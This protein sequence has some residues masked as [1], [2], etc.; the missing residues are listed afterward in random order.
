MSD[1]VSE[2]APDLRS[3]LLPLTALT[4]NQ[5]TLPLMRWL[6]RIPTRPGAGVTVTERYIGEPPVR[7]LVSTP[8]ECATGAPA[9]LWPH[10]GG[11][12]VGTPQFEALGFGRLAR[13]LGAVVVAPAYRLVSP[14]WAV[15]RVADWPPRSRNAVG[16]RASRC[17]RRCWSIR[18]STTEPHFAR[19]T[20][21]AAG[22]AGPLRRI[23]SGGRPIWVGSRGCRRHRTGSQRTRACVDRGG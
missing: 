10:G 14:C 5:R 6:F 16:T 13:E 15:A 4:F 20:L 7:V 23:G 21:V 18:C 3:A 1:A 11:M 19:T 17:T 12:V 9:L 22:S 2:V 8:G